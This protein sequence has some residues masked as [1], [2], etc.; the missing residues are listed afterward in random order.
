[1]RLE[2]E[3]WLQRVSG[4]L[5]FTEVKSELMDEIRAAQTTCPEIADLR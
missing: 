4:E 3:P 5:R 1:M 2:V